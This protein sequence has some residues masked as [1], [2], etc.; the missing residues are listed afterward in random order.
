V[1]PT[2]HLFRREAGRMVAALTRIFG[3]HNLALAEDVVQDALCR[4]L[5]V[6]SFRGVPAKPSAWLMA[7]AKNR[8]LDILRRERTARSFAPELGRLL[9]TE[10]TLAPVVEE[11]FGS[12]AIK[13]DELRMMFSCCHPRLP[14][15]AQV[16][17]M[18]HILCGFGV[19]EI[20]SA[21]LSSDS[22][23]EKRISRAKKVLAG[24]KRLFDLAETSEL[25]ARVSAV[26][27]ALYLLFNEGY[28]GACA[29]SAVRI[30]LCR[31]AMRLAALLREHRDTATPATYALSALMCLHAA[32]LPAR[33]DASGNLTSLLNQDRSLW[34]SNLLSEGQTLLDLSATGPQL[35]EYHV[36]AAI[37]SVHAR[38]RCAADTNWGQI[39]SLYDMLMTIRPSPVVALSRAIAVAQHESAERG[40]EE[41]R[42]IADPERLGAYPFYFA[43]MGELEL[44]CGRRDVARHHFLAA[45]ARARNSMEKR[46]LEQRVDACR[47]EA[48][49]PGGARP[50]TTRPR[51][52]RPRSL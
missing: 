29:E 35:T 40:L 11:L 36:E 18:L 48:P 3:V 12:H 51:G 25:P 33:V 7:T 1:E 16:A 31:E 30:E 24:S 45:V 6:W 23:I 27:R 13:D 39:V 10:W 37:A 4:A 46:F 9:D 34:D 43:A 8:A 22:A 19:S 47:G 15:E 42:T 49:K 28:H 52:P 26:H 2:G 41:L 32:R 38:A 5:E 17:L 20:A 50:R 14:E 44:R 21:F